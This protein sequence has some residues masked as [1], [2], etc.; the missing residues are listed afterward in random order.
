MIT[1]QNVII[2]PTDKSM[3][4]VMITSVTATASTPFTDVACRIAIILLVCIK[5]GEAIEKPISSTTRDAKA[6]T[7]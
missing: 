1:A 5:F 6:S 4:P 2:V 7:R 3:P